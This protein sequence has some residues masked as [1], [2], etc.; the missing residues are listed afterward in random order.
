LVVLAKEP[1]LAEVVLAA[2][3]VVEIGRA[4]EVEVEVVLKAAV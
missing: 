4:L 1:E 3:V 2:V